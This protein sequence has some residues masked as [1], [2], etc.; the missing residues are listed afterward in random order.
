MKLNLNKFVLNKNRNFMASIFLH[1]NSR[2]ELL[3]VTGNVPAALLN[4]LLN[5]RVDLRSSLEDVLDDKVLEGTSTLDVVKSLLERTEL[6]TDLRLCR[7]G[8]LE[9]LGL[10]S[11]NGLDLLRSIVGGGLEGLEGALDFVQNVLVLQNVL[12]VSEVHVNGLRLKGVKL[13]LGV[14]VTATERSQRT[15]SGTGKAQSGDNLAPVELGSNLLGGHFGV[16][17]LGEKR[18]VLGTMGCDH[19]NTCDPKPNDE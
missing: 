18:V 1:N 11:L 5:L 16:W 7:L 10:E 15:R 3:G 2:A 14:L 4:E 19:V 12:V 17:L 9:G 6:L 13:E 8:V